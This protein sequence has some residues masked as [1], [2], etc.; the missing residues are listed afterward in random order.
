[1]NIWPIA[2]TPN[3]T[4]SGFLGAQRSVVRNLKARRV[5]ARRASQ[6]LP[7]LAARAGSSIRATI[8]LASVLRAWS[9]P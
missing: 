1:M 6:A 9:G 2:P 3:D 7:L 8:I 4:M 5:G